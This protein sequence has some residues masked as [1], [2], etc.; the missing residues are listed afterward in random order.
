M[1]RLLSLL[2]AAALTALLC[3]T[4]YAAGS[5]QLVRTFVYE[6]TLYTYA[7]MTGTDRPITK[8]DAKIRSQT[9]PATGRMETV[10]QAG[11][12]V[13]YLL[14][15]DNSTSMPDFRQEVDTF[16]QALTQASGENTRYILA[17]FGDDFAVRSEDVA[18]ESLAAE[19]AT[20]PF[21]ENVTRLHTAI[22]KALDY[23]EGLPRQGNELRSMLI[24]SDAVQ[25]D[26]TGGV[27]YEELL[28]RIDSSDVMLHAIGFGHDTEALAS[29]D[30]L[31]TASDGTSW[32]VGAVSPEDAATQLVEYTWH[33]CV[34]GFELAGG[35]FNGSE[36]SVAVTFSSDGEL[37]CRAETTVTIPELDSVPAV[38][39][40]PVLPSPET[41][42]PAS[43]TPPTSVSTPKAEE[44]G[45]SMATMIGAVIAAVAVAAAVVVVLKKRKPSPAPQES[46]A[47]ETSFPGIYVCVE[48]LDGD[49]VS[50]KLER[51]LVS[52]LVIGR[53]AACDISFDGVA[54]SRQ[55]ARIFVADERV[56]V[57]DLGSQNGTQVN[58]SRIEMPIALRSG[59]EISIGGIRIRLKF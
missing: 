16:A 59:D 12:P 54:L 28:D 32:I 35:D 39:T 56:H 11:A 23:L 40:A 51:D 8:A 3:G 1:K 31:V 49:A 10:Q 6:N 14:L 42:P 13:T 26:P 50:E 2:T 45:G 52:E 34:V 27:P 53:D 7:D 15:L 20:V 24:L 17:T 57:E 43:E 9:F 25:Y 55:H 48:V 47:S 4:A 44:M 58:G 37:I 36:E 18:A 29:I 38:E 5:A 19:I 33:L 21:D 46:P 30:K 22:D 41:T